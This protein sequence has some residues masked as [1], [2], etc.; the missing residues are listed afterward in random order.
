[1]FCLE[2]IVG[3]KSIKTSTKALRLFD[4]GATRYLS[5]T[6]NKAQNKNKK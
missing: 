4:F 6:I 1:M 5:I 2:S 3:L